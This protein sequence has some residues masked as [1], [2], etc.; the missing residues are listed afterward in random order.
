MHEKLQKLNLNDVMMDFDTTTLYPSA[1]WDENSVYPIIETGCSFKP[2]MKKTCLVAFNNQNF[3]EDGKESAILKINFYN[4]PDLIFQH[5]LIKEVEFNEVKRMRNGYIIDTLR[6][7]DFCEIG[8][9][10]AKLS[11]IYEGVFI[12]KTLR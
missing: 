10:G 3:N 8:K 1:M 4:P 5:L 11:E 7:V 2:D 9:T 6:S 12:E